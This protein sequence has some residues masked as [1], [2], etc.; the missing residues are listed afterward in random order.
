MNSLIV[1][2]E[3]ISDSRAKVTYYS[4]NLELV[5]TL[6]INYKDDQYIIGYEAINKVPDIYP[7]SILPIQKINGQAVA[8]CIRDA[9]SNHGWV[10]VA[11]FVETAFIWQTA[12]AIS[13]ACAIKNRKT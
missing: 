7:T 5:Q 4:S 2:S 1:K 3:T 12:A 11:L 8:D 6:L 9:Y 13:I 10:S